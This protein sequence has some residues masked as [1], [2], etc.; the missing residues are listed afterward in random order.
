MTNRMPPNAHFP[1]VR[2]G[3]RCSCGR[4]RIA[5]VIWEEAVRRWWDHVVSEVGVEA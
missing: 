4:F 2:D 5:G 3:L 1:H